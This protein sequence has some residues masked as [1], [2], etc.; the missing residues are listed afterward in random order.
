MRLILNDVGHIYIKSK[1]APYHTKI[2]IS[3][4]VSY[5]TLSLHAGVVHVCRKILLSSKCEMRHFFAFMPYSKMQ[6]TV[7]KTI[8]I[9]SGFLFKRVTT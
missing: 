5:I 1:Q 8:R 6:A 2:E 7:T 3:T 4:R 9:F